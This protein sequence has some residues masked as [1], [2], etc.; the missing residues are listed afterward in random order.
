MNGFEISLMGIGAVGLFTLRKKK[1]NNFLR[2]REALLAL[3]FILFI[4]IGL[5]QFEGGVISVKLFLIGSFFSFVGFLSISLFSSIPKDK[6]KFAPEIISAI[7]QFIGQHK[8]SFRKK[9]YILVIIPAYNEAE[10]LLS[11]L[12]EAPKNILSIPVKVLVVDDGSKDPTLEA[13]LKRGAYCIRLPKNSGGG[14]ALRVG[15]SLAKQLKPAYIVTMDADGQHKFSDI[16]NITKPLIHNEADIVLGNRFEGNSEYSSR[17]RSVGI[18]FFSRFLSLLIG[19]Q[20]GD[21]SNSYRSFTLNALKKLDL[22]EK[23]HHTA[24]FVIKA[25]KKNLQIIEVPVQ[26]K[27]RILGKSKKGNNFI[28]PIRFAQTILNSWWQS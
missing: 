19:K 13:S 27:D 9:P 6:M 18:H 22:I 4:L 8:S 2:R 26:I 14:H 3:L 7:D 21:C 5:P 11:L 23:K 1:R 24:E 12:K 25:S 28:Y 17:L 15:F 16:E 20:I 10:N